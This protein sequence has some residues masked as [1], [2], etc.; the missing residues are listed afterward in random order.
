MSVYLTIMGSMPEE[1]SSDTVRVKIGC[2]TVD[3]DSRAS[4]LQTGNPEKLN[5]F[6]EIPATSPHSVETIL[7]DKFREFGGP[8]STP[9]NRAALGID[10]GTEWFAFPRSKIED[11]VEAMDSFADISA[12]KQD[13]A[14]ANSAAS[15]ALAMMD[16]LPKR[17]AEEMAAAQSRVA[18]TAATQKNALSKFQ[19]ILDARFKREK[20]EASSLLPS[21]PQPPPPPKRPRVSVDED[22]ASPPLPKHSESQLEEV[23]DSLFLVEK[24]G[25]ARGPS[26]KVREIVVKMQQ[27]T[28]DDTLFGGVKKSTSPQTQTKNCN[29]WLKE[30]LTSRGCI[31]EPNVANTEYVNSKS[32]IGYKC[33]SLR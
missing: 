22:T 15:A 27:A 25:G 20:E 11:V 24:T 8:R 19:R 3:A 17:H 26:Y 28:G 6:H 18:L 32:G 16:D 5:V 1:A 2:T 13:L 9:N 21:L 12:V 23:F 33:V 4:A 30:L 31:T 29:I 10:G 14:G 7:H